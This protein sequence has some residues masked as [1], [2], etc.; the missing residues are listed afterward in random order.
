MRQSYCGLCDDC[1]LGNRDFLE[2][3]SQLKQYVDRFRANWWVHCFPQEEAF[4][5]MEFRKALN[6]FLTNQECPGCQCGRGV[7]DCP[8]RL[9]A[10]QRQLNHCYECPDLETCDKFE[11]LQAE[12]PQVKINLRRRQLKFRARLH[13]QRLETRKH[14]G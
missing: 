4:S 11:F 2:T 12:F 8:I 7:E 13:H 10:Q 3:V 6:W 5:F 9:C 14:T 1:Q